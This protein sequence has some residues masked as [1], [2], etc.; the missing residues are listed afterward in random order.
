MY[1]VKVDMR[2]R[3]NVFLTHF[4]AMPPTSIPP[5]KNQKKGGT[6]G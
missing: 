4:L 5:E 2:A 3:V 1:L 6:L